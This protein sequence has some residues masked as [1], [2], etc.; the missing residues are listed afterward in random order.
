MTYTMDVAFY[1]EAKGWNADEL[2]PAQRDHIDQ[3]LVR[4]RRAMRALS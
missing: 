2:T 3:A 4:I 1:C